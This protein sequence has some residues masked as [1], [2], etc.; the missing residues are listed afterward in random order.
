MAPFSVARRL[1]IAITLL[2]PPS[3][4]CSGIP[5]PQEELSSCPAAPLGWGLHQAESTTG[6]CSEL[7]SAGRLSRQ[8]GKG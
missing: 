5:L 1:E 2:S 8:L 7:F 4:K 6:G 3:W